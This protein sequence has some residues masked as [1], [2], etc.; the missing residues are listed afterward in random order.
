MSE[1]RIAIDSGQLEN[2]Q[3]IEDSPCCLK[4]KA[5][6]S[7]VG[8]YDYA[9][10]ATPDGKHL[11][12]KS[13]VGL[14]NATRTARATK[15]TLL[16]HPATELKVIT[17]QSQ[18]FGELDNSKSGRPFFD[19]NKIRAQLNF[20]KHVT[21][22]EFIG[23]VRAAATKTGPPLDV[24]IGFYHK[25]DETPGVWKDPDTGKDFNYD[26]IM[27]DMVID[28]VAVG[29]PLGRCSSAMGCG[30]GVDAAQLPD[31]SKLPPLKLDA[32]YPWDQC[33]SDQLAAGYDDDQANRIC[34]AIKNSTVSHASQFSGI[35]DLRKASALVLLKADKDPLFAY[36]LDQAAKHFKSDSDYQTHMS[37]CVPRIM[38]DGKDV[39]E[40]FT[41]CTAEWNTKQGGAQGDVDAKFCA[42]CGTALVDNKCPNKDC[43]LFDKV[44]NV[45]GASAPDDKKLKEDFVAAKVKAGMTKEAAEAMFEEITTLPGAQNEP[46]GK[47]VPPPPPVK[48]ED[49]PTEKLLEEANK[50]LE[51]SRE[52]TGT[53]NEEAQAAAIEARKPK[54]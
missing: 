7:K 1:N 23:K 46:G 50:V 4:V 52:V 2:L 12:L 10:Q 25:L 48:P 28:H 5:T 8:V 13:A 45:L 11:F 18:I 19:R 21:P 27:T 20:D 38:K 34:A 6:I 42:I 15:I 29:V 32:P 33:I 35:K 40:A 16:D 30:I 41:A 53:F 9:D 17:S 31:T 3:I 22:D 43:A 51:K 24:S 14:L 44:V 39:K 26:A 54:S 49:M 37:E 36:M 47:G